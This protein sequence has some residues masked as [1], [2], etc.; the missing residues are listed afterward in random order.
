MCIVNFYTT[1]LGRNRRPGGSG[2]AAQEHSV[3]IGPRAGRR[4]SSGWETALCG[5]GTDTQGHRHMGG[6]DTWG[7]EHTERQRH[8]WGRDTQADCP[9]GPPAGRR[10]TVR[11]GGAG[12]QAHTLGGRRQSGL[13]GGSQAGRQGP[14]STGTNPLRTDRSCSSPPVPPDLRTQCCFSP[15]SPVLPSPWSCA[16]RPVVQPGGPPVCLWL[17][18]CVCVP[19][20]SVPLCVCACACTTQ[21]CLPP[22]CSR[23]ARPVVLRRPACGPIGCAPAPPGLCCNW[24]VRGSVGQTHGEE[25]TDTGG[26]DTR[27]HLYKYVCVY[28]N[29][30]IY[31]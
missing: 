15:S 22:S 12:P 19:C 4:G 16:A 20:V 6:T 26:T 11:P 28:I 24:V 25:H 9:V 7:H 10:R 3:T 30:Y 14:I 1:T 2:R 21:C 17:F 13:T 5:A 18:L 31:I 27:G 23:A 8:K 29:K